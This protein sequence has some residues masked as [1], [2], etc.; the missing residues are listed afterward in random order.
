MK[1]SAVKYTMPTFT[2]GKPILSAGSSIPEPGNVSFVLL[3]ACW[4]CHGRGLDAGAPAMVNTASAAA[5]LM[6]KECHGTGGK[7]EY[8]TLDH[9]YQ[10]LM[11]YMMEEFVR[12]LP[13]II[14]RA[15]TEMVRQIMDS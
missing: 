15:K 7:H 5:D 14:D 2:T 9:V 4:R 6:C 12:Q 1:T 13:G 8:V 11:P 3:R 10:M